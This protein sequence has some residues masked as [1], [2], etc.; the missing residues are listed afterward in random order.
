MSTLLLRL[1][2]PMQSWGDSSR[3][4]H[5][6]TRQEPTKSGVLGLLAAAQGRRRSDPIEDLTQLTFG[7]R[8]DQPG[9]LIRDF[10][11][12][13]MQNGKP[14]PLSY[15]F[16]LGD[17][18]FLAAVEGDSGFLTNLD[19]SLRS[20]I[21]P[22]YLG[23]RSCPPAGPVAIGVFQGSL[24]DVLHRQP[25]AA[26][27]W[28]QRQLRASS[29]DLEIVRDATQEEAEHGSSAGAREAIRDEPVSYDPER[30]EYGWRD[31]IRECVPGVPNPTMHAAPAGQVD[32]SR[33]ERPAG[34]DDHDPM[35]C[36]GGG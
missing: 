22:L 9:R 29:V 8:I 28:Y 10:H 19:E 27:R 15:R 31:V 1:A 35:A 26:A 18:L 36:L 11:T 5:R 32:V 20:P 7:V 6:Q 25:W 3:F 24:I 23:R 14:T 13:H 17:A 2:A 34:L 21:F 16:Y 33:T 12:A 30:R 4:A